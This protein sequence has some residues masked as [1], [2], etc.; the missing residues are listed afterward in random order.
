MRSFL[1]FPEEQHGDDDA[2]HRL[3]IIGKV[4]G[5]GGN[6]AQHLYLQNVQKHRAEQGEQQKQSMSAGG[7]RTRE[8]PVNAR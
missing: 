5:E 4:H 8:C 7:G 2:V 6:T 1:R 3:K